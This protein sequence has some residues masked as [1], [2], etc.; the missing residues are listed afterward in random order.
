MVS[1]GDSPAGPELIPA[2]IYVKFAKPFEKKIVDVAH[3]AG[4]DYVLHV[5][6]NTD[7]IIDQMIETGT[8]GLELDYKTDVHKAFELM[9]D[10][11]TFFGNID[12]SGILARGTPEMVR[13]KT[14]D[15]LDIY[16]KSNRFVLNSGCALPSSTPEENIKMII[17]T[18]RE[19]R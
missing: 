6:G 2:D 8:D 13:Q 15:L 18:A 1:N 5:C 10:K 3:Q 4:V 11:C 14:L 19:Y 12:P 17:K 16:S 9:K 7:I